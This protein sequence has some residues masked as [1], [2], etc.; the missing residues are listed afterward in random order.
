[1]VDHAPVARLRPALSADQVHK[2]KRDGFRVVARKDGG[3]ARLHS[4]PRND[5][6]CRL[7]LIVEALA[8]LRSRSCNIDGE[9]VC[10]DDKVRR[11]FISGGCSATEIPV[12]WACGYGVILRYRRVRWAATPTRHLAATRRPRASHLIRVHDL[13]SLEATRAT[14]P[15]SLLITQSVPIPRK[16]AARVSKRN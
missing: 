9:A 7:T 6:T 12:V 1:M 16:S 11:S 4:R 10:C 14:H 15:G 8:W 13:A 3:R 2:I 5:L